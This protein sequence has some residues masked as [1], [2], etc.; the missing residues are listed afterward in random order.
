MSIFDIPKELIELD[1]QIKRIKTEHD[2]VVEELKVSVSKLKDLDQYETF[3]QYNSDY[4]DAMVLA[5]L[6]DELRKQHNALVEDYN[7]LAERVAT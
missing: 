7:K 6:E 2:D 3:S 4:D 1:E 5:D